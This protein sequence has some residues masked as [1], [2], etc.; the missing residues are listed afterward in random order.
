M[1]DE[2]YRILK[3]GLIGV[4]IELYRSNPIFRVTIDT[5]ADMLPLWIEG[6]AVHSV[7]QEKQISQA[8][9]IATYDMRSNDKVE[10]LKQLGFEH[11]VNMDDDK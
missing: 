2:Y 5:L 1:S 3:R 7:E 10:L 9:Y 11:L 6:I 8:I 4:R